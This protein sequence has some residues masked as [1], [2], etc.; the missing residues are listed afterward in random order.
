MV[1]FNVAS[2]TIFKTFINFILSPSIK[3]A[4]KVDTISIDIPNMAQ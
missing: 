3:K 1:K 2:G 4:Q